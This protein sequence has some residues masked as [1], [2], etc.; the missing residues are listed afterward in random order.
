MKTIAIMILM[1]NTMGI[2]NFHVTKNYN[3]TLFW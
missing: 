1:K 3:L 2:N